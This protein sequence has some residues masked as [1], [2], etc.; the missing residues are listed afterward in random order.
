MSTT[1]SEQ[2]RKKRREEKRE[3]KEKVEKKEGE[4]KT[5]LEKFNEIR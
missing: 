3:K 1:L 2:Q 4:P 5:F